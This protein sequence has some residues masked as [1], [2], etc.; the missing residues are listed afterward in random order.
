MKKCITSLSTAIVLGLGAQASADEA[1]NVRAG[2][3]QSSADLA[4]QLANPVAALI[5]VPLQLN[6]DEGIGP[7]DTGDRWVLNI[8]PVVPISISE[9][10]NLISRTIVPVVWQ[11]DVIAGAGS[12][13]GVGDIVQSLFFSPKA[14][15]ASG[16]IWGAGPVILLPT[17]SDELLTA[18]KWGAGP[19]AV[20]LKQ[21]GPWTYG[22]LANHI[23]SFAGDDDRADV[24]ATFLQPFLSYTTPQAW[25]FS[26]NTEST[27]DWESEQW[28][29]PVNG[30][31]T[32]VTRIG[33]QLVSIGAGARYWAEGPDGGPEGWGARL[34][35]TLLFP[36]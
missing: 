11:D 25:T 30:I 14:P 36:K 16:W 34:V 31:V 21:Q 18:D 33:S 10:W 7:D 4:K 6:Y 19:T 28:S 20:A 9:D 24:N 13:S 35:F 29:V 22:A 12:Q 26:L 8:Q 3:P 17:G 2:Q 5:S 15:T 27:Y 32:K 1:A 23:W